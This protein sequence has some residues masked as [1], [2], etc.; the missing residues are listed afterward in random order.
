MESFPIF[1]LVLAKGLR[2]KFWPLV[3]IVT[4]MQQ[5][6]KQIYKFS[7]CFTLCCMI[8]FSHQSVIEIC[9]HQSVI[10]ICSHQSVIV[11]SSNQSVIVI[12]VIVEKSDTFFILFYFYSVFYV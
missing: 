12:W 11:I 9:S 6:A 3:H 2:S 4:A 10:I 1:L 8:F 5:R 7:V